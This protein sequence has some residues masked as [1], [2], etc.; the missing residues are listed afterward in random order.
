[1]ST[2]VM[3]AA[4]GTRTLPATA[5]EVRRDGRT[6]ARL[7]TMP[8]DNAAVR[9]AAEVYPVTAPDNAEPQWRFTDLSV[10]DASR[11]IDEALDVF[12]Y[13]GCDVREIESHRT[14]QDA[15]TAAAVA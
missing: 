1:M 8:L 3:S 5:Y 2:L 6:I 13:L 4:T 12:L 7:F 10:R 11:Y 15:R 14:A 9:V